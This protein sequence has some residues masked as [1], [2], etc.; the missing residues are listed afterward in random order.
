MAA[1]RLGRVLVSCAFGWALCLLAGCEAKLRLEAVE[2]A[3]AEPIRRSDQ[4]QA[5]VGDERHLVVVGAHGVVVSSADGG[6]TWQRQDLAGWPSL[7]DIARCPDG[8]FVALAYERELWTAPA[9]A[10]AWTRIPLASKETPQAITCDPQGR[11]WIVGS[12]SS[13]QSSSDHGKSWNTQTLDEDLFLTS[14]QFVSAE[15][16]FA[17]GEFGT[18]LRSTDG[19]ASWERLPS[20]PEEFYPEDA[21]FADEQRGWVVG[22]Q[23]GIYATTDGGTT[24]SRQ[25]SDTLAPLYALGN[26]AGVPHAV[27]GE[28]VV[29]RLEQSQWRRVAYENPVHGFLRVILAARTDHMLIAGGSGALRVLPAAGDSPTVASSP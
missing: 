18:V 20:L 21:W 17:T 11:W 8:S 29:L 26:V 28:G 23:G 1:R 22:L 14:I 7:L 13:I 12:F 6:A 5:A 2:A 9:D 27:G 25:V 10:G 24:W 19:G 3:R 4:F 15:H 16:A